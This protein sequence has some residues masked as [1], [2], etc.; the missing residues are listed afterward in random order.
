MA[1]P[2]E[3]GQGVRQGYGDEYPS[4]IRVTRPLLNASCVNRSV[5]TLVPV[6]HSQNVA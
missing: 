4:T 3:I 6:P 5:R 2:Y 1:R